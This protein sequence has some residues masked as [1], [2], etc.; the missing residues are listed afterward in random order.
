[1][2]QG[3][4]LSHI[5]FLVKSFIELVKFV[6]TIPGVF[7]F[8]SNRLNQDPIEKFF[9]QQRQRGGTHKNPNASQFLKNTQA[10]R[11][12]NTTCGAIKGNCRG[13]NG[14]QKRGAVENLENT[15][16]SKHKRKH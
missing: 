8:L 9:G 4:P 2:H 5:L 10:L 7:L 16:L 14:K 1:M 11:V 13:D 12:I 6:F 15:P 3:C